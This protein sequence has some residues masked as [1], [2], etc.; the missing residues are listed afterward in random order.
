MSLYF[1]NMRKKVIAVVYG[2]FCHGLFI[3]AGILMFLSLFM[4]FSG[5]LT[6]SFF[7][8]HYVFNV[9]LLIQFPFFHSFLLTKPGKKILR[10]FYSN[11]YEGKLDTTIYATIASVQLILLFLF[12]T[13]SDVVLW[14][15]P[16]PLYYFLGIG[17]L[18]GWLMLSISSIQA[19][20]GVQTGSLGWIS[21]YKGVK[22]KFP[23]MPCHGLFKI[24]RHPIYLSFC[25]ILWVSPYL[26]VDKL[27]VA[28]MYSL[29]CYLAPLLKEKRFIKI[30]GDRFR[31]YQLK[32]PY[33]FPK[34]DKLFFKN[35]K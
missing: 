17:Y 31:N 6:P 25:I 22:I 28:S 26:T 24:I 13:P 23:D 7:H 21:L 15:A 33:F 1:L 20:F 16:E 14:V 35:S 32:T 34:M 5:Q 29:Y 8:L 18:F 30:Y 10:W 3:C 4:G 11:D 12:W 9:F 2:L 19:G 27:I